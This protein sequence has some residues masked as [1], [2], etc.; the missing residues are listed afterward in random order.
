MLHATLGT[1]KG[2]PPG[3]VKIEE[4]VHKERHRAHLGIR[5]CWAAVNV[6]KRLHHLRVIQGNSGYGPAALGMADEMDLVYTNS[7]NESVNMINN[8]LI[9]LLIF[10][11]GFVII[12]IA[13]PQAVK[14][15]RPGGLVAVVGSFAADRATLPIID[16]KFN[17]KRVVGSQGMPEGYAPVFDLIRAGD[18]DVKALITHRLPLEET[19]RGLLLMDEKAEGVLKVVL[20]PNMGS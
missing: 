5:G 12:S 8:A 15:V 4:H 11:V 16:F 6:H 20:L 9:M 3:G 18:V 19:E 1:F 7:F 13:L 17:E 14:A 2:R 10:I